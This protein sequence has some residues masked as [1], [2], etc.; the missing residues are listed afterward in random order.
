[1][2]PRWP[3][4]SLIA[5]WVGTLLPSAELHADVKL[6]GIFT[7]HMV[8]QREQP[9]KIRGTAAP[10][11]QISVTVGDSTG[12]TKADDSGGWQIELPPQKASAL[13]VRFEVQGNNR[14]VLQDVLIGEVWLCSGQSNMEWTVAISG[15]AAEEIAAATDSLIRHIK[16]PLVAAHLPQESLNTA[17]QVC[18]PETAGGFTACG[19]YMARRLRQELDVPVGLVNSSWGGTRIEPWTPPIG[20]QQVPAL[21]ELADSITGRTPGT[22]QWKDRL[23]QHIEATERWLAVAK[24]AAAQSEFV[25]PNPGFPPELT[26]FTGNQDPTM[27]YNA[28]IH[29]FVGFPIRGAIWYQGESNHAEGLLYLEKM[30]ALISGWRT[31]WKRDFPFYFVQIAPFRYG[32]EDPTI[33][34]RFWE[35]QTQAQSISNTGMV[36]INDIA[37][38][39]DIHP[40]NKQDVGFRL[41]QLALKFDYGRTDLVAQSPEPESLK[42]EPGRLRIT[43]RNAAGG[44]R[45]RDGKAPSHFEITGAGVGGFLPADAVIDGDSVVLS[46]PKLAAPT[47]WRF[48]WHM[49]AEPNLTG[50]TGLPVGAARG[51]EIP[52][53][54]KTLP[55]AAEYQLVYDLDLSRSGDSIRYNVDRSGETGSFDRIAWL[56][57]LSAEGGDQQNVFVSADAFTADAS[58]I[59][60]PTVTSGAVFQQSVANVDI[61][62]DVAGLVTG[63]GLTSCGIEFWPHNYAARNVAQIPGASDSVYDTGDEMMEPQNG[64]GSMQIHNFS[65]NQTVFAINNWRAAENADVGI[66]NSTGETRDWTFTGSARQWTSKR[67]RVFVRAKK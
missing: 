26:P 66:G 27:L 51:G 3:L 12:K 11:E 53:F 59:G 48:A 13:P 42:V 47:A 62:S 45:T 10:G 37:T 49:L 28:M 16:V 1:M 34:P 43:F 22:P 63:R 52:S 44:L 58:K 29:P 67:L 60:I 5:F 36:V 38:V 2:T 6:A 54:L 33:L 55:V 65:A 41:A 31:L 35:A 39:N 30:K 24:R 17:W 7:D 23:Q 40:P 50:G 25:D 14:I 19:Y 61:F 32:N 56:L 9:L 15:N 8:L 46:S 4:I 18:S 57:E 64:Y 20:F 21:Q